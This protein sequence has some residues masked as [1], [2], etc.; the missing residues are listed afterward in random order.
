[1][2]KRDKSSAGSRP[3]PKPTAEF[4]ASSADTS[5]LTE[6]EL[7]GILCNPIYAGVGP[8]PAIVSDEQWIHAAAGMVRTEGAEQFLVN[9]L[10]I[11]RETLG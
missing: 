10:H 11:L 1:M 8:Y 9:L 6:A 2:K 5:S 3:L 4:V 7:R